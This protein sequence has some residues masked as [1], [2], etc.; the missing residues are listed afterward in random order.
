MAYVLLFLALATAVGA[1]ALWTL[2]ARQDRSV[3]H[4]PAVESE[5]DT[6]EIPVVADEPETA[7]TP[8]TQPEPASI[9]QEPIPAA[10]A[11]EEPE[12][13]P[14]PEPQVP[15]PEE[16]PAAPAGPDRVVKHRT[17]IPGAL[18]RERRAWAEER[19]Y[20]FAKH[21]SYLTDEWARGA[22]A[23]GA[24][25]RD[26]V[27]GNEFGHE[28]LLMDLGG[29]NVMA[30]RT[31]AASDVV[32]DFQRAGLPETEKSEDLF[33]AA[34]IAGF[35]V[36]ASDI[37]VVQRSQDIRLTTALESLPEE[38]TAVWMESEWVLAQT[39]K[40]ARKQQWEEMLA[41]MAMLADVARVLPPRPMGN[42]GLQVEHLDPT[43]PLPAA[44]APELVPPHLVEEDDEFSHPPVQRPE[45]PLELPTRNQP[46]AYGQMEAR[47]L[48]G[49]EV[50]AIADGH[51]R[52]HREPNQVR[53]MRRHV[54]PA[55]IF[56]TESDDDTQD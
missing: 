14:S 18:R 34:Q 50:G 25:P 30:M 26:I 8:D 36:F 41:P 13:E 44:P 37:G 51:E 9:E 56:G 1:V 39:T 43:R 42:S 48:G 6:G 10:D 55:T 12:P 28:M 24:A 32:V 4:S 22:A 23:S 52:P 49:D 5:A 47:P 11:D 19:G 35:Q 7:E 27:A 3:K 17:F 16:K 40:Y 15:E 29:V 2:A 21:D 38:V 45:E 46:E 20:E 54:D 53:M 33:A 31:G